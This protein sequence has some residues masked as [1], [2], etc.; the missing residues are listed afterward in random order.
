MV[1]IKGWIEGLRSRVDPVPLLPSKEVWA[2]ADGRRTFTRA[3]DDIFWRDGWQ[4][5]DRRLW[6]WPL[7]AEHR[8]GVPIPYAWRMPAPDNVLSTANDNDQECPF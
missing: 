7:L 2:L 4:R 1:T 3:G 8:C 5:A 6:R